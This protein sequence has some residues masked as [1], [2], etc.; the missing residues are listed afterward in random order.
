[1]K[2]TEKQEMLIDSIC[3]TS[4]CEN[5]ARDGTVYCRACLNG[6]D[7]KATDAAIAL[8]KLIEKEAKRSTP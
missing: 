2:L 4:D 3:S 1:M 8:K 5:E 7:R 6:G